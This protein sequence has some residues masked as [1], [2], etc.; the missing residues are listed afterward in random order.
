MSNNNENEIKIEIEDQINNNIN[1]YTNESLI[2]LNVGGVVFYTTSTTLSLS[3]NSM[4]YAMFS[5]ESKFNNPVIIDDAIFID[6]DPVYFRVI[7]NYLRTNKLIFD[8]GI[9]KRGLLEEAR[10]FCIESLVEMI[11]LLLSNETN[12]DEIFLKSIDEQNENLYEDEEENLDQEEGL[13]EYYRKQLNHKNKKRTDISRAHLV[14]I[15]SASSIESRLRLQGIRAQNQDLSNLDLGNS[16]LQMS[17]LSG[18]NL[19]FAT[20][21]DSNLGKSDL[22]YTDMRWANCNQA[23]LI[24]VDFTGADLRGARFCHT[25]LNGANFK[26]AKLNEQTKFNGAMLRNCVNL[27]DEQKLIIKTSGGTLT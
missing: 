27:T 17:N 18:S 15:L 7:L 26:N 13:M 5:K 24:S 9:N 21:V 2:K 22:S 25:H 11:E 20:F 16:N 4:L 3:K 14:K 10:Y 1:K 23:S 8:K 6:R 12:Q 19:S